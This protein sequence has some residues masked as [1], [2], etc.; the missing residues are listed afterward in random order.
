MSHTWPASRTSNSGSTATAEARLP[1]MSSGRRRTRSTYRPNSG[2]ASDGSASQ[3]K[4]T[5]AAA[6]EPVSDLTH[7]LSTMSIS[8]SPNMLADRPANSRRNPCWVNALRMSLPLGGGG[9]VLRGGVVVPGV[10][11]DAPGHERAQPRA[12]RPQA[13]VLEPVHLRDEQLLDLLVD[14][15]EL[16]GGQPEHRLAGAGRLAP[17][18]SLGR[19]VLVGP[20]EAVHLAVD[21]HPG[22]GL[23]GEDRLGGAVALVP[24]HPPVRGLPRPLPAGAAQRLADEAV[25]GQ[26]AQVPRAVGRA[27]PQPLAEL[28]GRHRTV[29]HE[30]LEDAHPQRVRDGAQLAR[31]GEAAGLGRHASKVLFRKSPCNTFLPGV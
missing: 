19:A 31:V 25:L 3:K 4:V 26:L 13:R 21:Q 17:L 12:L 23:V 30:R 14:R 24:G 16:L 20:D 15:L 8:E 9:V 1:Q 11:R 2:A 27:L 10:C 22:Q 6:L 28:A 18:R 29:D 7:M 5:P